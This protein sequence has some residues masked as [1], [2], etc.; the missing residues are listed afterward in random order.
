[1][2]IDAAS[3]R[4]IDDAR[5]LREKISLA[6]SM[7]KH[8]VYIIDEVHMLTTEAFN[9][10][11]KTIEEPPAHAIFILATTEAHKLPDTIISRTQRFQFKPI[12]HSDL[13]SHLTYIADQEK[14]DISPDAIELLAHASDGGF[15]DAISMLDQMAGSGISPLDAQAVR[16]LLGW[17]DNEIIEQIA[18]ALVDEQ[19]LKALEQIDT[20]I[21]QGSQPGQ[22]ISQL[23]SFWRN[24]LRQQLADGNLAETA[25]QISL[26]HSVRVLEALIAISKSPWPQLAL[27][28]TVVKLSLPDAPKPQVQPAP[29][30]A[31]AATPV[32]AKPKPQVA[33]TIKPQ[34]ATLSSGEQDLWMK[35]LA[36][37]KQKNNSLYALLRASCTVR[38]EGDEVILGCRFSFHRDR[39]KEE[40][41]MQIIEKALARTFGRKLKVMAQLETAPTPV[42]ITPDPAG[43]LMSSA[44][45]ILGGEVIE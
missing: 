44:L 32:A 29:P 43:E 36:Q 13:I 28:A 11:L 40:K 21:A 7:G 5:N 17:T 26:E 38:F 9:A 16:R 12:T 23:I 27:E 45:E 31:R 20:A 30:V 6:P 42:A 10:L 15:R 2:E 22:I 18:K 37:I 14:I 3:N 4:G 34:P 33:A 19:P 1:V 24:H 25:A 41:N 39:L 8:K 35:S